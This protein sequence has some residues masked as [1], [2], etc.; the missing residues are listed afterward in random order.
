MTDLASDPAAF[1]ER[2]HDLSV[3][4]TTDEDVARRSDAGHLVLLFDVP[5]RVSEQFIPTLDRLSSFDCL[6]VAPPRYL[7][8]TVTAV[9]TVVDGPDGPGDVAPGALQTLAD[10]VGTALRGVDPFTVEFPRLNLFPTV[11]YSELADEGRFAELNDRVCSLDAVPT[12]D[13]DRQFVPHAAL[14]TF[15]DEDVGAVV[16]DLERDRTL[17]VSSVTVDELTLVSVDH[18]ERYPRFE[19]VRR[20]ALDD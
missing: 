2:R 16:T 5:R 8:V 19:C 6:A 7:H 18:R 4:P 15:R 13:R 20:Y 3:D 1:W 11:V 14:G 9:G 12:H 17:D 10:D